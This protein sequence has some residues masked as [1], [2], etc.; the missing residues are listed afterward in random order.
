[1]ARELLEG[2]SEHGDQLSEALH[3]VEDAVGGR[4]E[5]LVDDPAVGEEH[6]AVGVRGGDRVVG[7]HHD[8]LA[9]LAHGACA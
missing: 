7:D 1:M 6:G 9:E 4:V 2:E 5:H 8:R 3:A